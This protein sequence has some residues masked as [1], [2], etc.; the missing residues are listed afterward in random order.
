MVDSEEKHVL[1]RQSDSR[2]H[3]PHQQQHIQ[4]HSHAEQ[5]ILNYF[6]THWPS[7]LTVWRYFMKTSLFWRQHWLNSVLN[8]ALINVLHDFSAVFI[9]CVVFKFDDKMRMTVCASCFAANW[10]KAK[11]KHCMFSVTQTC[12]GHDFIYSDRFLWHF[13]LRLDVL[14]RLSPVF[15]PLA[16]GRFRMAWSEGGVIT[17][18]LLPPRPAIGRQGAHQSSVSVVTIITDGDV[19]VSAGSS[20]DKTSNHNRNAVCLLLSCYL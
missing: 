12:S 18:S 8:S 6:P 3:P 7:F 5:L 17:S 15:L 4:Q 16:R 11:V 20:S 14:T 19:C 9:L 1:W 2:L 10:D 13:I